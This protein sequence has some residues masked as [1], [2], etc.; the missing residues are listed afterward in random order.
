MQIAEQC[1]FIN[2]PF[3]IFPIFPLVLMFD[4]ML[5]LSNPKAQ[6]LEVIVSYLGKVSAFLA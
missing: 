2:L 6:G 1:Q 5:K 3:H 4:N